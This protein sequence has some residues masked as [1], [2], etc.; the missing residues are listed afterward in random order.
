MEYL[1]SLFA[2]QASAEIVNMCTDVHDHSVLSHIFLM[3]GHHPT[4]HLSLMRIS[5]PID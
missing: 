1:T 4:V 2:I 5:G 3:M